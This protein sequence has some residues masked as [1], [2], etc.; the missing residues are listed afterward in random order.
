M[1]RTQREWSWSL[2][3]VITL[4]TIIAL[5]SNT[6]ATDNGGLQDGQHRK[7]LPSGVVQLNSKSYVIKRGTFEA[8]TICNGDSTDTDDDPFETAN[9]VPQLDNATFVQCDLAQDWG[10]RTHD[11]PNFGDSMLLTLTHPWFFAP[12]GLAFVVLASG[13]G[14]VLLSNSRRER[15]A[16]RK[17]KPGLLV[18]YRAIQDSYARGEI[19]DLEFESRVTGLVDAGLELPDRDIFN[20]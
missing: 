1:T 8:G 19:N 12:V 14:L 7:A 15:R 9:P 2:F 18:R 10:V 5:L 4:A 17:A 11:S 13:C 16:L 20:Q 6:I 3:W